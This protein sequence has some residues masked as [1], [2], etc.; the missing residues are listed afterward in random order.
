MVPA[1]VRLEGKPV[2][3]AIDAATRSAIA[4]RGSRRP[5]ALVSL[6]RGVDSPFR[7]YLRR[8]AKAAQAVGIL[9]H[10]ESLAPGQ[11]PEELTQRLVALDRNPEVDAVLL[12][13][14]LPPPFDFH[15]AVSALRPEKDVDGVGPMNL[16]L[17]VAQHPLHVPAVARA[18][19]RIARHYRVPIE[20]ER[21][22]VLGRSE[23]VG[24]PLAL[25]LARREPGM[26]ATVTLAHSKTPDLVRTLREARTIFSCVGRAGL[27]TRA[28]V[29]EGAHVI[30]VGVSSV[31]DPARPGKSKS[32]GDA[33]SASLEGWAGSLTPVP[34]GVG[35]V[36]VAELMASVV[37]AWQL[38]HGKGPG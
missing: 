7:F 32:V 20:G 31:P 2:A 30:D 8:Q 35:P 26:N 13:H 36:T 27:L 24:L 1:T 34:G 15:R 25:L 28:N 33:D 11:G 23:T 16:G 22:V 6:H 5:P 14:P 38:G 4:A 9:F 19:V 18:A 29:P 3:E 37:R 10:E 12:E 21:V 17:L